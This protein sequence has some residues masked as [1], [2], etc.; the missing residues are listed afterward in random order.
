[1]G[2]FDSAVPEI[3]PTGPNS[4]VSTGELTIKTPS[5]LKVHEDRLP[6]VGPW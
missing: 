1:M 4:A 2:Q 5:A 6:I 3:E